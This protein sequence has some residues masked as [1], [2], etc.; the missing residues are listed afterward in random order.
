M[1]HICFIKTSSLG[2]VIHHMPALVDARRHSPDAQIT[3]LVEENYAPLVR[4]HPGVDEVISVSVRRW[5]KTLLHGSTWREIGE[6]VRTLR[7]RQFD[8]VI[9]TQGLMRSALVARA[10]RGVRHGYAWDSARERPTSLLYDRRYHVERRIHAVDRNR[11]LT[12]QALGYTYKGPPDYGFEVPALNAKPYAVLLHG[13]ARLEKEWPEGNWRAVIA[14][15][16]E[17]GLEVRLPWGTD[18]ERQRSERLAAGSSMAHVP[19]RQPLDGVAQL[20][21]GASIVVGVDTGLTHLAAALNV[22]LVAIFTAT[23]P[24]LTGPVGSGRITVVG[25]E[26]KTPSAEEVIAAVHETLAMPSG[27]AA[28]R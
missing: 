3:W 2:D 27:V 21:A 22:P 17:A 24:H 20:I 19:E 13:S 18:A 23:D 16:E 9:D 4:M 10:V 28:L 11:A 25:D 15:L 6:F 26:G 1:R 7:R 8:A 5:R 12:A 14:A